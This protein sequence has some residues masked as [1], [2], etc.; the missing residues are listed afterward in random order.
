MCNRHTALR[1]GVRYKHAVRHQHADAVRVLIDTGA[2]VS[3]PD[4]NGETLLHVAALDDSAEIVQSLLRAG[5]QINHASRTGRTPLMTA[6]RH[7]SG[8]AV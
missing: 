2:R 8:N 7:R 3:Q 6:V 4:C 5:A 1:Y